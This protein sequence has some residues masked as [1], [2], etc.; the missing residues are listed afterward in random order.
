MAGRVPSCQFEPHRRGLV[1][2]KR[3]KSPEIFQTTIFLSVHIVM[4][5]LERPTCCRTLLVRSSIAFP[6]SL[7]FFALSELKLS[8]SGAYSAQ[9]SVYICKW[10]LTRGQFP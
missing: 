6:S 3:A 10:G 2:I 8:F 7:F 1:C 9:Y 4:K 5:L